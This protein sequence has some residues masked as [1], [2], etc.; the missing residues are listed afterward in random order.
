MKRTYEELL[1]VYERNFEDLKNE[2]SFFKVIQ[3]KLEI[4]EL[5]EEYGLSI[6]VN[7]IRDYNK[8]WIEYSKYAVIGIFG[9]SYSRTITWSDDGHQPYDGERLLYITFPTGPYIFSS[10]GELREFFREF[11]NELKSMNPKYC[12]TANL[13]LYFSIDVAAKAHDKYLEI[14]KKYQGMAKKELDRIKMVKLEKE[15]ARL[16]EVQG[17]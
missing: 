11:F 13:S 10:N 9:E 8:D 14:F 7:D 6:N 17:E 16:K 2:A 12:D 5:N 4:I 1:G 15:L 3:A